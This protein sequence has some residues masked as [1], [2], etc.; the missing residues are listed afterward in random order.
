MNQNETTEHVRA[1]MRSFARLTGL[2]PVSALPKRYLWTDAF[3][4]C[5][6]LELYRLT[7]DTAF[8]EMATRLVDQVHHT[9]GRY[10]EDDPRTGWISGLSEREGEQHPTLGGLRIGKTYRERGPAEVYNE[11]R[12]WDMDGQY[13]HYL[14]KWMHALHQV[15][16]VTREVK[17]LTW[18][19]ELAQTV[20]AGFTHSPRS[21]ERKRMFWKMST[22][23]TRP[24]VPSMGQHDPLD[25]FVTY[26]ELQLASVMDFGQS[27]QPG[28]DAAI[29][30]MADIC[31]GM[32][33]STDDPLGTGGLLADAIRIAQLTIKRGSAYGNLLESLLVSGLEG[34]YSF[35]KGGILGLPAGYRLAFRELGLSIGLSG[36]EMLREWIRENPALFGRSDVLQRYVD[37][38]AGFEP[39]RENIEQFWIDDT[40]RQADTWTGH[41]EINMV[42]LATS[43]APRGFLVIS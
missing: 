2:E 12:E 22:D 35:K 16:K 40:N 29:A 20:H 19:I 7:G 43:L 10:R 3:A 39:V 1:I 34:A 36:M 14:T 23:L 37:A 27:A 38:L 25:G 41:R 13:Y 18:A 17:Y 30:D 4:V 9:L 24:L 21:G 26:H 33:L 6:Y 32:N 11:R 31:K 28:L 15:S 5:N 42:M 8:T